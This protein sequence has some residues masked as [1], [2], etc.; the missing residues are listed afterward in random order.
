M[1]SGFDR[2]ANESI[3]VVVV[4]HVRSG[5]QLGAAKRRHGLLFED[6]PGQAYRV[7]HFLAVFFAC[8]VIELYG[9]TLTGVGASR[10]T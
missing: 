1:I 7:A 3:D 2:A 6:F 8:H 10:N 5:R 4:L 9:G